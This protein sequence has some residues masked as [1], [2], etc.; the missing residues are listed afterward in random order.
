[1][2]KASHPRTQLSLFF[3]LLHNRHT[4]YLPRRDRVRGATNL[5]CMYF[6]RMVNLYARLSSPLPQDIGRHAR[7]GRGWGI[8]ARNCCSCFLLGAEE[9]RDMELLLRLAGIAEHSSPCFHPMFGPCEGPWKEAMYC[10]GT[11]AEAKEATVPHYGGYVS[12]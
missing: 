8:P 5:Y 3:S 11:C 9:K 4:L 12:D 2:Y 7:K 6:T 1:M 10:T